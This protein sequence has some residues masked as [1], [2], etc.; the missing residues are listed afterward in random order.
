MKAMVLTACASME[1]APLRSME[2]PEPQPGVRELRVKVKACGICRTDLH[3]IEGELPFLAQPVIPGHQIVG[4]IDSLGPGATRFRLGER[5]GIAWLRHTCGDCAFCREGKENLCEGSAFTGYHAPGGFAE[6][7]VVPEAFAYTIPDI[8]SDIEAA[9]L[10]CAG[11]IG[12]RS[13]RRSQLQPGQTLGLYGFGSSA[14][15]VL[16]I[17]RHWGCEVYVCTRQKKHQELAMHLGAK[18]AGSRAAEMPVQTDSAILFAPA[19]SLVP[20]ALAHL[21][22][23]G[24]LALAGIYMTA[25]PEM[26]YERHLFYEKNVLSVTANTRQ[27][28]VELLRLAAEIPIRPRVQ[29]FS[30]EQANEALLKLKCD[31]INGTGVLVPER[32]LVNSSG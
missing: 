21:R 19:G 16:Q 10:L 26:N 32:Y 1:E 13:L 28:A 2:W 31:E 6:Y 3:V 22:K 15:I 14:H 23:G 29:V 27:D 11:I 17:A 20:V 9:P 4:E 25:I 5:V 24:T 8:F 18:W 12:Y 7:A 30:M